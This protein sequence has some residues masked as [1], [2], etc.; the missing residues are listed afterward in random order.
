MAHLDPAATGLMK[1]FDDL[2]IFKDSDL[3]LISNSGSRWHPKITVYRLLVISTTISLGSAKAVATF[4]DKE[5]VSTTIEWI[6][7]VAVF[8]FLFVLGWFE[9]DPSHCPK[10]AWM[11]EYDLVRLIWGF[12]TMTPNYTSEER[13]RTPR[14]DEGGYPLITS[15]RLI[16]SGSVF[17][18]G[19]AK[20]YLSYVGLGGGANVLDWT[21][22]A[23]VTSMLYVLGLYERNPVNMMPYLFETHYDNYF[24]SGASFTFTIVSCLLALAFFVGFAYCWSLG[25]EDLTVEIYDDIKKTGFPIS[26]TAIHDIS[27]K[28]LVLGVVLTF[29]LGSI[30]Y[31]LYFLWQIALTF[32]RLTP[33][34]KLAKLLRRTFLWTPKTLS[35]PFRELR[36]PTWAKGTVKPVTKIY[37]FVRRF[38]A[39]L[40]CYSIATVIF[41]FAAFFFLGYAFRT[42]RSLGSDL[43]FTPI[44]ILAVSLDVVYGFISVLN[45][46]FACIGIFV[47]GREVLV[48]FSTGD[49]N[50]PSREK[51]VL[52]L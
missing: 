30:G 42:F 51:L 39:H 46:L 11:F 48:P 27:M 19:M 10:L 32:G 44:G 7:G 21:F 17:M 38:G 2:S 8:T 45:G 41:A 4:Y 43:E 23:I 15:Y 36:I 52:E 40:L 20:A 9:E 47:A 28:V 35:R 1:P 25:L 24:Y 33:C 14:S 34:R 22:G 49:L 6:A 12:F 31:S 13:Q 16:V 3:S 18:F 50:G 37:R 26:F 29:F 5:Y